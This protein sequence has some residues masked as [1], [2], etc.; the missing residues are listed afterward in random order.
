MQWAVFHYGGVLEMPCV[1]LSGLNGEEQVLNANLLTT[2]YLTPTSSLA[3]TNLSG[4]NGEE[5][6][7]CDVAWTCW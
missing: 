4:L 5:Q 2:Y 7:F 6:V 3:T 1:D